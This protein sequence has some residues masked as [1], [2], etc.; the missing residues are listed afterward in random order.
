MLVEQ[1][2]GDDAPEVEEEGPAEPPAICTY[3]GCTNVD[4]GDRYCIVVSLTDQTCIG[5]ARVCCCQ[6]PRSPPHPLVN[7]R[8]EQHILSCV[9]SVSS[10]AWLMCVETSTSG[11]FVGSRAVT[12]PRMGL[13]TAVRGTSQGRAA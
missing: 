11:R 5:N 2:D 1:D 4:K 10:S 3:P 13:A 8:R 7:H 9:S 12:G 6:N